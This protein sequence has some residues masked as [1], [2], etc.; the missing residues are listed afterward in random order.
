MDAQ[1]ILI[2]GGYG[3]VG[4]RIAA[5]LASDYPG[6]VVV[7]GRHGDQAD[8]MA[9]AIGHGARGRELDVHVPSSIARAM[10]DVAVVVSCI[11]QPE[12][13]LMRAAIERGVRYTDIT[14]HLAELGR[15]SRYE[16]IDAAARASGAVILLGAGLVPGI[17]NV[18]VRALADTLGG[19]DTI[20]TSLLL[21]ADD[22][23]GPASFD[24][25][26][27][28]LAM[29]FD[30]HTQGTDK[31]TR[32]FVRPRVVEF[33][34]P[35]PPHRAYL[36]PFSDQVLYPRTMNALTVLSR[37]ALDPQRM[38]QLLAFLVDT[39]IASVLWWEP[40]R[41]ALVR[42]RGKRPPSQGAPFALRVDVTKDGSSRT[43]TLV[44]P[45]QAD[46]TATGAAALARALV[47]REVETPGAWMPEQVIDTARFFAR[48]AQRGSTVQ[49]VPPAPR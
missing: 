8:A 35:I 17:S 36:F 12:R 25:F 27:N 48:L 31:V 15:H 26:L 47:E 44:G 9:A 22:V 11:D 16:R 14:P 39:R 41:R 2:A 6:R 5:D 29:T 34:S 7:A 38:E 32:A 23:A 4:S 43:A 30:L 40:L 37:L 3:V 46:A 19:A 20:E 10:D 42:L 21:S 49:L 45:V 13:G 33:P 18:M 1:S 28:E 24:Y